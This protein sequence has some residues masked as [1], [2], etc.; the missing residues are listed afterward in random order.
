MKNKIISSFVW[1]IIW[2]LMMYGYFSFYSVWH[3][4]NQKWLQ[5]NPNSQMTEK[6]LKQ[7]SEKTGIWED[8]IQ[9]RLDSWETMRDI[10][11]WTWQRKLWN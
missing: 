5:N 11:W 9:K 10:M 1:F 3:D 8:E 2:A 6:R 7:I 4:N